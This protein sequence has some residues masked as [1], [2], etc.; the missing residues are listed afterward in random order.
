[1]EEYTF[2]DALTGCQVTCEFPGLD[3]KEVRL[4]RRAR[5]CPSLFFPGCSLINYGL[6]LMRA[7]Y[8]ALLENGSVDGISLL[9]CGKILSFEP[10]GQ[11]ARTAFEEQLRAALVSAG[12]KRIVAACP[13]CVIALRSA[14]AADERTA[15]IEVAALP[16][17]LGQL[18]S[19]IDGEVA[20]R[21]LNQARRSDGEVKVCVHD[22]CPDRDAGE[23][24]D[25]VRALIPA[26]L[27]VETS[28]TRTRSLC[29]GS[30]LRAAGRP[31]EA[32]AL[33]RRHGAQAAEAGACAVV[34]ACMSCAYQL[35]VACPEIQVVHYLELLFARRIAWEESGA[36]M[37][38]RFLF[39]DA[40]E[41]VGQDSARAFAALDAPSDG[42]DLPHRAPCA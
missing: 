16:V 6:P 25:G 15:A 17:V 40:L 31:A 33:A 41:A 10:D 37:K 22:S 20:S 23:F 18:G 19:R 42:R 39:E 9:C 26:E 28:H 21:M 30:L 35:S 8:N 14:L 32:D 3:A 24:A 13:N 12:V 1:M 29:C 27:S 7:A 5:S 34:T 11:E 4:S 38:L 2:D 36:Y